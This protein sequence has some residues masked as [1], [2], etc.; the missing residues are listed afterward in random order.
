MGILPGRE[1]DT[2]AAFDVGRN[3]RMRRAYELARSIARGE[4]ALGFFFGPPGNGKTHL[5]I[6][7]LL[8]RGGYFWRTPDFMLW[9][10]QQVQ[11]GIAEDVG[12]AYVDEALRS[13]TTSE[14]LI[15]F[16]D[17]GMEKATEKSQEWLYQVL[18]ARTAR[19]LPTI[20]TSNDGAYRERGAVVAD[21]ERIDQR[22][23]SRFRAG[24][25]ICEG[26]DMR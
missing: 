23:R 7:A 3:P 11:R 24:L 19:G 22:L 9:M 17:L 8:V 4:A 21:P 26:E 6:A 20:I 1:R 10:R 5:A 2:F 16:D 15:V 13:Y 12:E 18:D 25:V 14:A